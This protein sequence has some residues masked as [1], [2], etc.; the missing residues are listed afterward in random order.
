MPDP[1]RLTGDSDDPRPI[2]MA[3]WPNVNA[4]AGRADL[5][6][7]VSLADVLTLLAVDKASGT[8]TGRRPL[9]FR[10]TGEGCYFSLTDPDVL[11]VP[12]PE[13]LVRYGVAS[14]VT[15]TAA[16]APG[17]TQWHS[18]A[19]GQVHS[20]S[21]AGDAAVWHRGGLRR[22]PVSALDEC[23]IDK[24]GRWLLIKEGH[25]NRIVDL[26]TGLEWT[27]RNEDGAAGHSDMGYGYMIGEDDYAEVGGAFRLWT[28]T[29]DGPVK[30]PIVGTLGT[31]DPMTRYVSHCNAQ[32]GPPEGQRVL[33][34]S[35]ECGLVAVTI[36]SPEAVTVAPSL[37]EPTADYWT[38]IRANLDPLGEWACWSGY[39]SG[40]FDLYL[41]RI[42]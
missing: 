21:L 42:G 6:V 8:V 28:F 17:A 18:S 5:L 14:G 36:G 41:V 31:W 11:Y 26:E 16:Y 9:P 2:G 4:H 12:Q 38:Q 19:D 35:A 24:G 37:T 23:Q 32:P 13:G 20:C 1:I 39:R 29:E 33:L 15:E 34:S 3:Y 25:D 10:H 27:I 30:G 40:R 22:Y 7:L